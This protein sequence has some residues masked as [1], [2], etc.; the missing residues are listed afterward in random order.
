MRLLIHDQ[1]K[2]VPV[3]KVYWFIHLDFMF[4]SRFQYRYMSYIFHQIL[5][6][7][8]HNILIILIWFF[9]YFQ[10]CWCNILD[11]S[12]FD[13]INDIPIL[14]K[15]GL[16][17]AYLILTEVILPDLHLGSNQFLSINICYWMISYY[18]AFPAYK[19]QAYSLEMCMWKE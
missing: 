13:T 9:L 16:N 19:F 5:R 4:E 15:L 14:I 2:M 11:V 18:C 7:L 6:Y 17:P 1:C 12:F 8:M 3:I 10:Y